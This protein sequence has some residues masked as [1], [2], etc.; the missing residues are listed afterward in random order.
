MISKTR[1]DEKVRVYIQHHTLTPAI[2]GNEVKDG[3]YCIQKNDSSL[4][5]GNLFLK[6]RGKFIDLTDQRSEWPATTPTKF[7]V[8]RASDAFSV[9]LLKDGNF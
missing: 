2:P 6:H 1:E 9:V 8:L 5:S 3:A 4:C 7:H